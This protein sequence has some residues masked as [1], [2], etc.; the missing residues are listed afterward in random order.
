MNRCI[1]PGTCSGELRIPSSKSVVHRLLI[2][3]ALGEKNVRI[4]LNG[5]SKDIRATADCLAALGAEIQM[6]ESELFVRPSVR[7]ES[8]NTVRI[9]PA[10]ESGSTLRFLVPI[11]GALK[12]SADFIMEGRLSK[13]PMAP[14]D[15]ILREHGMNIRQDGDILHCNGDLQGGM[16]RLPGNVSSQYFTGLLLALPLLPEDSSLLVDGELESAAYV[17]L[18]EDVLALAGIRADRVNSLRWHVYGGQTPKLPDHVSAEGDWSNAAFFLCAGALSER[19]VCVSGLNRDSAQGDRAILEVLRDFGAEVEED[20]DR[21]RVKRRAAR[22]LCVEAGEIPDLVPVLA[23]LCCGAEGVSE[24][25][26]AAR[27]RL[28]ESDR[29]HTTAALINSLGG[30]AEELPD[31]IRIFGCGTLRGGEADAFND[32]RIAMSAAVASLLCDTPV[33]VCGAECVEKSYPA[34]W[35]DFESVQEIGVKASK[36]EDGRSQ[37]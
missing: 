21:V 19:G 1:P 7:K 29:L 37:R 30:R 3:A 28:K 22:P 5:L 4:R 13:R 31:G 17:A 20:G 2:C 15:R 18:T 12:Q 9:L 35:R 6:S 10:G 8:G 14:F 33:T 36:G 34:F 16:F 26:G 27:L 24:I 11:V 25:R 32:H 23:V